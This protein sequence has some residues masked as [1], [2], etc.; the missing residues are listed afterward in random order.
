MKINNGENLI[1]RY[2][3]GELPETEQ[4]SFERE[5]LTDRDK[6]DQVWS[7]ETELIDSYVRGEMS[8]ADRERFEGHYMASPLH[9]E[10]VAIARLLLENIDQQAIELLEVDEPKTVVPRWDNFP[11]PRRWLAPAFGVASVLA[12]LLTIGSAWVL[13]E[14]ARLTEQ[15]A[16]IQ[17]EAQSERDS[18]QQREQ[19]LSVRNRELEKEIA[20]GRLRSE[21]LKAELEQLRGQSRS[22]PS[23]AYPYLLRPASLRNE[24]GP[25]PPTIRLLNGKVRLW[26][27]LESRDHQSY[28][29]RLQTAEGQE[30]LLGNT[31]RAVSVISLA[32]GAAPP[33]QTPAKSDYVAELKIPAKR[34]AKGEYVIILFGQTADGQ[35][36]E[37]DRYFFRTQ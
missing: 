31:D 26:M 20:D 7:I 30:I 9:R 33:T 3:L 29:I 6:F 32:N 14:R 35:S 4:T 15:I 19:E 12:F 25:A 36:E 37:I 23:A 34:L 5:L 13:I 11:V 24:T 18:L 8:R 17:N 10:R 22:I 27:Q 1:H 16:K 2:L 28:R 21:Q